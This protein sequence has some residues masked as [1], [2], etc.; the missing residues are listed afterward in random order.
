MMAPA[1]VWCNAGQ[2]S[3]PDAVAPHSPELLEQLRGKELHVDVPVR[4]EQGKPPL[5][6][7]FEAR[8]ILVVFDNRR[9]F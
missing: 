9:V 4:L 1:A 3:R 5:L 7:A 8:F 6:L 2:A